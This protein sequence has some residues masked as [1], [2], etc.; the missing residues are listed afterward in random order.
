[1]QDS[2]CKSQDLTSAPWAMHTVL[3]HSSTPELHEFLTSH[4]IVNLRHE[5]FCLLDHCSTMK[6]LPKK[7]VLGKVITYSSIG[8][9]VGLTVGLGMIAGVYLDRWLGTGPWLTVLGLVVGVI[10]GFTR[11]FQIGKEFSQK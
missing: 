5:V 4:I 3:Q 8:I 9:Q 10:S 2:W 6:T 11:L 7:T 1:M